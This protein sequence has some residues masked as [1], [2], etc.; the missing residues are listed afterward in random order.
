MPVGWV[1]PTY[2]ARGEDGA[3][4]DPG[5]SI[6]VCRTS[7][8]FALHVA[9]LIQLQKTGK[10]DLHAERSEGFKRAYFVENLRF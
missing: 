9:T 1:K 3:A 2:V 8:I 7:D 10:A 5:R 6:Q 4:L